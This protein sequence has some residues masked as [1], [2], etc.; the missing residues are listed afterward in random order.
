[1]KKLNYVILLSACFILIPLYHYATNVRS[2]KNKKEIA[3]GVI[4]EK[5]VA[6]KSFHGVDVSPSIL[7][8]LDDMPKGQVCIET[9]SVYQKYVQVKVSNGILKVEIK[10]N[11]YTDKVTRDFIKVFAPITGVNKIEAAASASVVAKKTIVVPKFY[12]DLSSGASFEGGLACVEANIEVSSSARAT[13]S[14][15]ANSLLIEA[16]SSGKVDCTSI[17]SKKVV[18]DVSS[19]G[20]LSIE[21]DT[22][23][24]FLEVSSSGRVDAK[25][26]KANEVICT[27]SS[28]GNVSVCANESL[29]MDA[30][31]GGRILYSGDYKQIQTNT[32]SGGSASKE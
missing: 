29:N 15:K 14:S 17:V 12:L 16:N 4:V 24:L 32:S 26:L 7:V 22:D 6:V 2:D 28:V 18:C 3:S 20:E 5:T 8:I 9:D 11:L 23:A 19:S 10:G 30:S 27:A 21:G 13:L 1:M 25:N 31:S